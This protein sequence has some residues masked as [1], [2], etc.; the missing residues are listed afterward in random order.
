MTN[1]SLNVAVVTISDTRNK[2]NDTSG[3]KL[4]ELI[5][6]S[7]HQIIDRAIVKDD[8]YAIR[9]C[10][11]VWIHDPSIQVIITTGGTGLTGRDGTPEA[12]KPLLDKI[13]DGFAEYFRMLSIE[14]IGTSALQSR[15]LA[16]VS[17]GTFVFCL[18]GS[19]AAC[20]L[21][22][23]KIIMPQLSSDTKPCN[24]VDLTQRLLEK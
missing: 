4:I 22:W 9:A 14:E 3:K 2:D 15:C 7:S 11:S 6:L 18:P 17:N 20:E 8:I 23:N 5:G 13:I 10:L 1:I 16:G 19:T 12:I 21:G 24:L